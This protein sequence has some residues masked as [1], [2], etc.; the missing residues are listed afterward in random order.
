MFGRQLPVNFAASSFLLATSVWAQEATF[1]EVETPTDFKF[2]SQEEVPFDDWC[3]E[4]EVEEP[5]CADQLFGGCRY[6]NPV[7]YDAID[8]Y[9]SKRTADTIKNAENICLKEE[10]ACSSELPK[11]ATLIDYRASQISGMSCDNIE[12]LKDVVKLNPVVKADGCDQRNFFKHFARLSGQRCQVRNHVSSCERPRNPPVR[13]RCSLN[14]EEVDALST[15]NRTLC[16]YRNPENASKV[17]L[18]SCER[19]NNGESDAQCLT[20]DLI[21]K[22][23]GDGCKELA[24]GEFDDLEEFGSPT[25]MSVVIDGTADAGDAC[26]FGVALTGETCGQPD[27]VLHVA[28][29]TRY[30][31]SKNITD[32][33][34]T[35]VTAFFQHASDLSQI[36]AIH[37]DL[38]DKQH[39]HQII[40]TEQLFPGANSG[41]C[42]VDE[43][44]RQ[45]S[46]A[47]L[48]R[49]VLFA[50]HST[51]EWESPPTI[52]PGGAIDC[53]TL[54]GEN[55]LCWNMATKS[56]IDDLDSSERILTW[57]PD[58][59]RPEL[60]LEETHLKTGRETLKAPFFHLSSFEEFALFV[61]RDGQQRFDV[62]D[63]RQT[64][65]RAATFD[66]KFLTKR[67][68]DP[69]ASAKDKFDWWIKRWPITAGSEPVGS[70]ICWKETAAGASRLFCGLYGE[71]T[72]PWYPLHTDLPNEQARRLV[73]ELDGE[74]NSRFFQRL[75]TLQKENK[76]V[77]LSDGS[78]LDASS[79]VIEKPADNFEWITH[80]DRRVPIAGS[81][82]T[83]HFLEDTIDLKA[84]FYAVDKGAEQIIVLPASS[85]AYAAAGGNAPTHPIIA[86]MQ[87]CH[88]IRLADPTSSTPENWTHLEAFL[89]MPE[90]DDWFSQTNVAVPGPARVQ[91]VLECL[92]GTKSA[93]DDCGSKN[94]RALLEPENISPSSDEKELNCGP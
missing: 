8:A 30:E 59:T 67:L 41:F 37:F 9:L 63:I 3:N 70:P 1:P 92:G 4:A 13:L 26:L 90:A 12:R 31:R 44:T 77:H 87:D 75:A 34:L 51:I 5:E 32:A 60:P 15:K 76:V 79:I 65:T 33:P 24:A 38:T 56:N 16:S 18:V 86:E 48:M 2:H 11:F 17:K 47:Y 50:K 94:I 89:A 39:E 53:A 64:R 25:T 66:Q 85:N 58:S 46:Q 21:E 72:S 54:P 55:T 40:P 82:I 73:N 29:S 42:S 61:S 19:D 27:D 49:R 80:E 71:E 88:F 36:S 74:T 84:Q 20:P 52:R 68:S 57:R 14:A 6:Q 7:C 23:L 10:D 43:I 93:P 78:P 81:L 62:L 35:N 83:K 69:E 91:R 22:R 28:P 45:K